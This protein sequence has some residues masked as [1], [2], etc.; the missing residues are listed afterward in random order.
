[1][2][3]ACIRLNFKRTSKEKQKVILQLKLEIG[4]L[5]REKELAE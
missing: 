2:I 3:F 1:M 5:Q 4:I